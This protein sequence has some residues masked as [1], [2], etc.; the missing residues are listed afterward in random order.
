MPRL[1][2][3]SYSCSLSSLQFLTHFVLA[4]SVDHH[5]SDE[6]PYWILWWSGEF[7]LRF[8]VLNYQTRKSKKK[9][10]MLS[11]REKWSDHHQIWYAIPYLWYW[12]TPQKWKKSIRK[13]SP[14]VSTSKISRNWNNSCSLSRLQFLTDFAHALSV[15]HYYSADDP[16]WFS[17][18]LGHFWLRYSILKFW[19]WIFQNE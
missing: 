12:P 2:A 8:S 3:H 6:D 13:Y 9:R 14:W 17:W 11:I 10:K 18:W 16:Y 5:Y 19:T 15:G 4:L 1:P 7:W